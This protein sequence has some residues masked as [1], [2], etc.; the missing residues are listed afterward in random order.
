[1]KQIIENNK[2]I[3]AVAIIILI[4]VGIV[5]TA[6]VGFNK[7]LRYQQAQSIDIYIEQE[8]DNNKIKE[9]SNE[10]LGKN[11]IV[12]TV[13]IYAD[14]VSI[15]AKNI[16][17]DQKNELVNKVKENYE[18]KQTA[19]DTEINNIAATKIIDMYKNYVLPIIISAILILAYM[20]IKYHKI[21]LV[22]ILEKTVLIPVVGELVLLSVI[23]IT[24]IPIGKITPILVIAMYIATIWYVTT[25]N[26][27][28]IEKIKESEKEKTC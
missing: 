7:E 15:R 22:K 16:T 11:N 20:L 25:E 17:E 2:K 12:D 28:D 23:A 8:F 18:F 3:C 10:V 26:E 4:I 24:R 19:E 14:M 9:I 5:V 6:T 27:K 21:G 13:E 1:M